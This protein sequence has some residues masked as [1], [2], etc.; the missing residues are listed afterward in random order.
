MEHIPTSYLVATL[1]ILILISAF[2][3]GTETSMMA[4]NRYRLKSL[5]Q[6]NNKKAKRVQKLLKN[7]E[8]LIGVILLG[9][10]FV[11]ILASAIFTIIVLR[12]W[13]ENT[14]ALASLLL[15]FV[16]LVFAEV[17][18]KT[19]AA[20][21]PEKVA[22]N[23]SFIIEVLTKILKPFVLFINYLSKLILLI[24]RIKKGKENNKIGREELKIAV[25]EA[26]GFVSLNYQ[27]M[28]LDIINLEKVEVDD[29][30]IHYDDLIG[31]EINDNIENILSQLEHTQHTRLLVFD[32]D[33]IVGTIHTRSI[34]NL[35]AS[36]EF[37]KGNLKNIIKKPYF[38]P[39][40]ISLSKQ[41]ENFQLNKR[42]L[43]LVVD[44]YGGV[45]GMVVLEDILEEIVGQFTSNL[46][47]GFRDI[48][49]Q[50]DGSYLVD[51]RVTIRELNRFLKTNLPSEDFKTLNGLILEYLEDIPTRGISIKIEEVLFEI[52]QVSNHIIKLVKIRL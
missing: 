47:E 24:F 2:F 42:R 51:G 12:V 31:I 6:K 8:K 44:E 10:N 48:E 1:I 38:I 15:T 9:N 33:N 35:L 14:I 7:I 25:R 16:I 5:V 40:G 20:N 21:Y 36:G 39:L 32:N 37:N 28:L 26:K 45:K 52:V 34:V 46:F 11:N 49:K 4:I 50:K 19:F 18:P 3:S 23:A 29:I 17:T 41:L 22:L 13:G 30:M 27:K 43:A